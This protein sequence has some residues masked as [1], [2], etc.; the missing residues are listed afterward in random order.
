MK[1]K[2]N[3]RSLAKKKEFVDREKNFRKS[4]ISPPHFF[5]FFPPPSILK[6]MS[7][8]KLLVKKLSPLAVLPVRGSKGAAGYDLSSAKDMIVPARGKALCPT[9]LS[10]ALPEGVYGRIAP[11]SSLSWKHSI[12]TGAGVIDADYRGPVG[13]VLFNHS[14]DDFVIKVGDRI[15]QLILERIAIA[16]VEDVGEG[17]LDAT[18]RGEGGYGSTGTGAIIIAAVADE[19]SAKRTRSNDDETPKQA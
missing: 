2:K 15:A 9:D 10:I 19:P 11:R 16:E 14:D 17:S 6:N 13:V 8:I 7:G 3:K 12:Q 18:E 5:P 4:T 1:E